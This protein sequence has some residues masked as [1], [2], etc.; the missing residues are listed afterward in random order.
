MVSAPAGQTSGINAALPLG[1]AIRGKVTGRGGRPLA[2]VCAS[3]VNTAAPPSFASLLIAGIGGPG[4]A[5][6]S[7]RGIYQVSGLPAGRYHVL[8]SPCYDGTQR[9]AGQWF[10]DKVSVNAATVVRVRAGRTS[11]GIGARLTIGGTISGRV[12]SAARKPLRNICV[13]AASSSASLAAGTATGRR[14]TY[15]IQGLASGRYTVE[16]S[17]CLNENLITV[18]ARARVTAPHAT[19]G[20]NATMRG[21]GSMAGAVTLS[22]G[23]PASGVCVEAYHKNAAAPAGF[24][25][26]G[27]DGSYQM[28]GL[29]AG[30]YQ[31]YFGDPQCLIASVGLAPQWYDNQATQAT[32]NSVR[33]TV[34]GTTGSIDAVLQPDGQ[35]TG[36]VS[37]PS[38]TPLSGICVTAFP[39]SGGSPPVVAVTGTS[40][41]YTLTDL[42]PGSYK[43]RFSAGCGATGYATQWYQDAASRKSAKVIRIAA[44]QTRFAVDATLSKG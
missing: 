6:T 11:A 5:I 8:F 33:V 9:Y 30:T 41:G 20:V 27:I 24:G 4:P 13:S 15:T 12:V 22:S 16:F 32:A 1:G 28:T 34:G 26:T 23:Q 43:V 44:D 39:R 31:V 37:G 40:G 25:S 7:S 36:T 10:R 17:P 38:A 3:A 2:G 14:G 18:V 21:G 35:I 42:L 29:S 19:A